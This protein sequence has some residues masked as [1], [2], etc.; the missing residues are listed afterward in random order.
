MNEGRSSNIINLIKC[1]NKFDQM[2]RIKLK[3]Y[4]YSILGEFVHGEV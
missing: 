3:V 4:K 1:N 2:E